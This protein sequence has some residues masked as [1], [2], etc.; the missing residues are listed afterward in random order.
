MPMANDTQVGGDHYRSP[1]QHWDYV[2]ANKI[3]Y[4]E[5]QVIKYL[6]RWRKK[7]GHQ[8]VKK[9]QHYLQKLFESEGITWDTDSNTVGIEAAIEDPHV[10][11]CK[12]VGCT[13]VRVENQI[14][15]EQASRVHWNDVGQQNPISPAVQAV[16]G[17]TAVYPPRQRYKTDLT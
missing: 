16:Q 2:L 11:G 10:L 5:A 8:D 3:P 15:A 14:N 1:I 4:L 7:N 6:T 9:A 13:H 17:N 12:C